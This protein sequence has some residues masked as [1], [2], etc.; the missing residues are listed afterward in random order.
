MTV[1]A[2]K[3]AWDLGYERTRNFLDDDPAFELTSV[4]DISRE[5]ERPLGDYVLRIYLDRRL[6]KE[7]PFTVQEN[8]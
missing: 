6:L 5:K 1:R 7:I 3:D 4:L 8:T 2:Y